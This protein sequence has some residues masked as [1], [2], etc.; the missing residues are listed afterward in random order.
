MHIPPPLPTPPP[1]RRRPMPVRNGAQALR[2]LAAARSD[3]ARHETLAFLLD[4]DGIGGVVTVISGTEPPDAMLQIVELMCRAGERVPGL[5]SL[6]VASVR[7][8]SDVP[9]GDVLAGDVDRWLE[10]SSIAHGFGLQ[11]IEWYVIGRR[12]TVCPRDLLGEP[13]RWP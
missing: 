11:L 7:P 6:V 2:L 12:G 1:A 10:A 5:C 3:P 9:A 13:E 8:H 4:A